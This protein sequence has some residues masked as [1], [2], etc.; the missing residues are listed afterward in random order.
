LI[1]TFTVTIDPDRV[2][3]FDH[4]DVPGRRSTENQLAMR[5]PMPA[6]YA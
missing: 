5:P 2:G 3:T 1:G 4:R 6:G